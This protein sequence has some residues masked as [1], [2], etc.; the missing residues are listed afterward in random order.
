MI[1]ASVFGS[2]NMIE[3][4]RRENILRGSSTTLTLSKRIRTSQGIMGISVGRLTSGKM[5][6]L[7]SRRRQGQ[8]HLVFAE[9]HRK[10]SS[11]EHAPVLFV[12][13]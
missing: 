8:G 1:F 13:I 6:R 9:A 2:S 12:S 10:L 5:Q 3:H 7:A 11:V 4:L